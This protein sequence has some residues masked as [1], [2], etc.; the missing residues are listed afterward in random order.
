MIDVLGKTM[1]H[2]EDVF[3]PTRDI[4]PDHYDLEF[5]DAIMGWEEY[6]LKAIKEKA[7]DWWAARIV[8]EFPRIKNGAEH[9]ESAFILGFNEDGEEV[10]REPFGLYYQH[11]HGDLK[12]HRSY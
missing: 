12:E 5:E 9:M 3:S 6:S 1:K 7:Q 4:V 10:S 2:L 11:Y 8:D